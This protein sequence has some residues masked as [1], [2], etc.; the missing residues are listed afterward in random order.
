MIDP[1]GEARDDYEIF[2]GL[3]ERLG[4]KEAF[5]EGRSASAWLRHLYEASRERARAFD[6]ALPSFEAFWAEGSIEI[7]PPDEAPVMLERFRQDPQAH[8]L[9]T[10]SGKIEIF[11]ETI[12]SFGYDDCV[13]H[14]AWFEP[15]EWLG[16]PLAR[17]YPLHLIS[18]QPV[19]RLH[20]QYDH[21]AVSLD[22]KIRGREAALM[23]PLDAA[24]R[25]IHDGDVVR[26]F[27]DRGAC[28]AGVRLHE[29]LR[30]GVFVLPTGAWYDPLVPGEPGSLE[31]HGN[32]NVLTL[33][34]GT[35]K[36][37]QGCS[38]H[39]ALVEVELFQGALPPITAFNP[40]ELIG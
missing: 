30:P 20:S 28:L 35:S 34:K 32:P 16:S 14:P 2:T 29:G 4:V 5:T 36:L 1:V 6:I 27:N 40:P 11:S 18:H 23:H 19:T 21:G 10:P 37:T 24:A 31:K 39:S 8:R 33:D 13:G 3:A 17:R 38:A 12:A 25:G 22:S 9:P 7:P 26:V 15:V